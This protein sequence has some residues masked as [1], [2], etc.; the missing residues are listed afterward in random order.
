MRT[1]EDQDVVE[2]EPPPLHRLEDV[3]SDVAGVGCNRDGVDPVEWVSPA[4]EKLLVHFEVL[5]ET[6]IHAVPGWDE[7]DA[8]LVQPMR[9]SEISC[10]GRAVILFRPWLV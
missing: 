10:E 2:I 4:N 9:V 6:L 8:L 1:G 5:P 7:R 3:C